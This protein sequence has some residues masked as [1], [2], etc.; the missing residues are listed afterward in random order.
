MDDESE[1]PQLVIESIRSLPLLPS[2]GVIWKF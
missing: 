2:I 1:E